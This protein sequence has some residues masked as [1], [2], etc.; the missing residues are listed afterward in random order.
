[1]ACVHHV[2]KRKAA[3]MDGVYGEHFHAAPELLARWL[4]E[5]YQ[6]L[7]MTPMSSWPH[8]MVKL[9][10]IPKCVAAHQVTQWRPIGL[11][12]LTGKLLISLNWRMMLPQL[13]SALP[14]I[15]LGRLPCRLSH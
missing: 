15:S 10:M 9:H 2:P 7:L 3:G 12:P 14:P 13:R 4:V 11:L 1:L 6:R 5:L 8:F